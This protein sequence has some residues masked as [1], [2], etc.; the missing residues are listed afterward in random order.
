MQAPNRAHLRYRARAFSMV[1]RS[2][3][4][5]VPPLLQRGHS[6]NGSPSWRAHLVLQLARMLAGFEHEFRSTQ[7]AL[8][9]K[10][11]SLRA[12]QAFGHACVC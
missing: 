7:Y 1:V 5:T 9:G 10:L 12:L 2:A 8:R 4:I 11:V 3:S 6:C